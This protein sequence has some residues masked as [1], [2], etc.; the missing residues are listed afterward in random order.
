MRICAAQVS[1]GI[2]KFENNLAR[3]ADLARLAA[4]RGAQ[5]VFFPE[6]SLTGYAPELA[7]E[8]AIDPGDPRLAALQAVSDAGR[9]A[10][11][12]GA[13]V[14]SELGVHI[15]MLLFRPG[16]G[17]MTYLKKYLYP[18]EEAFFVPGDTF[19]NLEI[20]RVNI[21]LAV[22]YELSVPAHAQTAAE[23]GAEIYAASS[24]KISAGVH[25]AHQRLAAVA[26]QYRMAA[27]LANC[28]GRH[29]GTAFAG[30][31]AVWNERGELV[32]GLDGEA[33][34]LLVYDTQTHEVIEIGL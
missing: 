18:T 5:A 14:R 12:V 32:G 27:L 11:G 2:G 20:D 26:R 31:S 4:D 10:T 3:Q 16:L 21:G 28:T 9:V 1:P 23:N 6:L 34:G 7:A 19:T 24:A 15:G 17:R 8:L 33:E 25:Q 13:P 29:A 22:C 30:R